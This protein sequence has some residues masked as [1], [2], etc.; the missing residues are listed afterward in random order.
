MFFAIVFWTTCCCKYGDRRRPSFNT[1]ES[2]D[3]LRRVG[4]ANPGLLLLLPSLSLFITLQVLRTQL[5]A[6][7]NSAAK[8]RSCSA[9]DTG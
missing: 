8:N 5:D 1:A 3:R 2:G 9:L 4:P 7:S 6:I